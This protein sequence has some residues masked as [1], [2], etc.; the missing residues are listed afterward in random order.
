MT[1]T[2]KVIIEPCEIWKDIIWY[3]WKYQVSNLW[4]IKSFLHLKKWRIRKAVMNKG[5]HVILLVNI[6]INKTYPIKNIVQKHFW[7]Y[8]EWDFVIN[9]DWNILN[10]N[11]NNLICISGSEKYKQEYKLW[12]RRPTYWNKWNFWK[13]KTSKIII[14]YTLQNI[15]VKKR[16]CVADIAKKLLIDWW[17]I[18]NCCHWKRPTAWGFIWKYL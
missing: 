6:P 4:R 16:E 13:N 11:I 2:R 15:E 12:I 7:I 18:S 14:Q 1:E 9:K 17:N 5:I 8:N 3:E 10:S